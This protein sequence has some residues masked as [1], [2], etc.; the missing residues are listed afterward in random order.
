MWR[1]SPFVD[2]SPFVSGRGQS[3][4]PFGKILEMVEEEKPDGSC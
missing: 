2:P 1:E 3:S 4:S